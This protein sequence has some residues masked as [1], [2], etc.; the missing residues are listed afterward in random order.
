MFIGNEC[1][2]DAMFC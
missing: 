2:E 1:Y